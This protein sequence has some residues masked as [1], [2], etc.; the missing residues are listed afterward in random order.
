[1]TMSA[2]AVMDSYEAVR[3]DIRRIAETRFSILAPWLRHAMF[4][5]AEATGEELARSGW[6]IQRLINTGVIKAMADARA[7]EI[8]E[9]IDETPYA[10]PAPASTKPEEPR[11]EPKSKSARPIDWLDG[12]RWETVK[13]RTTKG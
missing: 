5:H 6:N 11:R 8:D 1:M 12:P 4:D 7:E 9:E 3:A 2:T 13:R 10:P